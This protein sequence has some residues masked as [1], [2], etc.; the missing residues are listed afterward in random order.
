[1][2]NVKNSNNTEQKQASDISMELKAILVPTDFSEAAANAL[3]Y[4]A[5]FAKAVNAGLILVHAYLVPVT[6]DTPITAEDL[7]RFAKERKA[8]LRKLAEDTNRIHNVPVEHIYRTGLPVD[9]IAEE[10]H[11]ADLIIMGMKGKGNTAKFFLGSV[12]TALLNRTH[13]PVIAIPPGAFYKD[14]DLIAFACDYKPGTGRNTFSI[15]AVLKNTFNA[16]ILVGNVVKQGEKHPDAAELNTKLRK[17][18][19]IRE[20]EFISIEDNDLVDGLNRFYTD[21]H[22]SLLV[23]VHHH[24]SYLGRLFRQSASKKEAFHTNVP[25]LVMPEEQVAEFQNS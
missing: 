13:K 21:H 14:P 2:S 9:C 23:M 15:L 17:E 11:R 1:M 8:E 4:A 12:T 7:D 6:T 20:Q 22:A 5:G 24:Y 18:L 16:T 3:S 19:D 25:L 10:E